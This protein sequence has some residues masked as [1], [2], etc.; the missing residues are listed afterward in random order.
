MLKI[1]QGKLTQLIEQTM[2]TKNL[3]D[4]KVEEAYGIKYT[5][6]RNWRRG[7]ALPSTT[8]LEQL[9]NLIGWPLEKLF[10]HISELTQKEKEQVLEDMFNRIIE[11]KN[12]VKENSGVAVQQVHFNNSPIS[13]NNNSS[14]RNVVELL[15]KAT[16]EEI[17]TLITRLEPHIVEFFRCALQSNQKSINHQGLFADFSDLIE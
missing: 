12:E 9:A 16:K 3:T 8:G 14:P 13:V 17:F 1:N 11:N 15:N 4:K 10:F 5:T 7:K 6:F 2:T